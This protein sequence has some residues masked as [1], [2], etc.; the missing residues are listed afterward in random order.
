MIDT[1]KI[2]HYL[3]NNRYSEYPKFMEVSKDTDN[4]GILRHHEQ[5]LFPEAVTFDDFI[6][7]NDLNYF[8]PQESIPEI[9]LYCTK[10]DLSKNMYYTKD[11]Q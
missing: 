8:L 10:H 1:E 6:K 2:L 7:E 5:S 11:W 4:V 3:N 9:K